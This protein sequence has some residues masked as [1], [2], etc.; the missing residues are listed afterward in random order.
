[1]K[2]LVPVNLTDAMLIS[3]GAAEPAAGEVAWNPATAYLV[4]D[5]VYLAASHR[6]YRR[7]VA[8][9][10]ATSPELDATNW[11]YI[12]ATNRWGMFDDT[13]AKT[14]LASPLQVVLAPGQ[15][16]A[17]AFL[18]LVG[19]TL[20]V[21]MTEGAGGPTVYSRT[22]GLDASVVGD[23][24]DYFFGA[25]STRQVVVLDDLPPYA[26]GRITV[27]LT[28]AGTVSIEHCIVGTLSFLGLTQYGA[29]AG[30]RDYSRKSVDDITG[31]VTLEERR[32]QKLLRAQFRAEDGA[33]NVV[34]GRLE[35]LRA[36]PVVWV[37]DN[38]TGLE[39]L[40]VYGYMRD[41]RLNLN[42]YSET[43]YELEVEG[44]T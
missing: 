7:K 13:S 5:T 38:G 21:S 14:V 11:S 26:N 31:I 44:M 27:T 29:S 1:M 2:V 33:V 16:N 9:T 19:T 35:A 36:T 41:F 40:V 34:Q 37:G 32:F 22:V 20:T 42:G 23:W 25:F 15:V 8:G 43:H 24:Y 12:G 18:G 28:G 4:N 10:S 39:P 3:S 17:L 6:R 30:I